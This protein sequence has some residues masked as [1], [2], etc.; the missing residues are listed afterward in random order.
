MKG[1]NGRAWCSMSCYMDVVVLYRYNNRSRSDQ[2]W[3]TENREPEN[4]GSKLE[5]E[6]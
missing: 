6:K 3:R 5:M 4:R 1:A 2:N